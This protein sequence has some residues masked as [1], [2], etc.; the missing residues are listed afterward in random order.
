MFDIAF[1]LSKKNV[2]FQ[3]VGTLIWLIWS[4]FYILTH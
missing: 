2:P 3:F 1:H 4:K